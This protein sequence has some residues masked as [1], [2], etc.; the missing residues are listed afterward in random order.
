MTGIKLKTMKEK[1]VCVWRGL[2]V[3]MWRGVCVNAFVGVNKLTH[4]V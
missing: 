2:C 3:C 1:P 4:T